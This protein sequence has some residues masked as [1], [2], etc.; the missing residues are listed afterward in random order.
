MCAVIV[1]IRLRRHA[2]TKALFIIY[3]GQKWQL[4]CFATEFVAFLRSREEM[5]RRQKPGWRVL[6]NRELLVSNQANYKQALK[7]STG[8]WMSDYREAI[9]W[10]TIRLSP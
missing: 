8:D 6:G 9:S 4:T 2:Q 1:A 5:S 7:G 10:L 3:E